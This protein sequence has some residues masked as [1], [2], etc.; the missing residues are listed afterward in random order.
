MNSL[1]M[2]I[3]TIALL[4]GPR[5]AEHLSSDRVKQ[6]QAQMVKCVQTE[7]QSQ[8]QNKDYERALAECMQ[9]VK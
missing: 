5:S 7:T 4:C 3:Q 2:A 8:G 6:C 9:R 1:M